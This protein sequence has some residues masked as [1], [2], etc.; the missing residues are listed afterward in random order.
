VADKITDA[1]WT[2]AQGPEAESN[3]RVDE[4]AD[5]PGDSFVYAGVL[6]SNIG[7]QHGA[8]PGHYG[9]GEARVPR[10]KFAFVLAVAFR[11]REEAR[12]QTLITMILGI[13]CSFCL[14]VPWERYIQ[15]LLS[16]TFLESVWNVE[17]ALASPPCGRKER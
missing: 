5:D 2:V 15:R 13:C 8:N 3:R 10:P 1:N 9:T 11:L 12:W 4:S 16:E 14:L 6:Y 17:C 7:V